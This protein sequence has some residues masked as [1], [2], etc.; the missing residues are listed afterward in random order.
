MIYRSSFRR[1][2]T[3][4]LALGLTVG[5][6][7]AC[8]H[9]AS[10]RGA[11]AESSGSRTVAAEATST[12]PASPASGSPGFVVHEWGL[13]GAMI[14]SAEFSVASGVTPESPS[15]AQPNRAA[16]GKPVIYVH[17]DEG[18]DEARF[19][20]V[21]G[22]RPE[23]ML[24]QWPPSNDTRPLGDATMLSWTGVVAT[25]GACPAPTAPPTADSIAC[26]SVSDQFC[27][28][29][30]IP[31][32]AA[33]HAS[34]LHIGAV[35]TELLFYRSTGLTTT[36][37]PLRII[38]PDGPFEVLLGGGGAGA[39]A[40]GGVEG[41]VLWLE[42]TPDGATRIRPLM[43][44]ERRGPIPPDANGALTPAETRALLRRESVR[45]GLTEAEADAFVDAWA[46]AFFDVCHRSG[47]EAGGLPPYALA[48]AD[49]SLLYF[50]PPETID[51]L[52]PLTT[53]PPAREVRRVF[54][55]RIVGRGGRNGPAR[56]EPTIFGGPRRPPTSPG[57]PIGH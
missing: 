1:S 6:A 37:L 3:V 21:I 9:G 30:E 53:T 38:R 18:I 32:Y 56:T 44:T 25:R 19:D 51:A 31:R 17:L 49:A 36:S 5:T 14:D 45:R 43:P 47:P 39:G 27:E 55:V 52:I 50:A 8:T 23:R 24:E 22:G 40:T 12:A 48:P 26:A 15:V 2:V 13:I 16:P 41:P 34:C 20:L 35:Q 4:T 10:S 54:L 28:A 7:A 11:P 57:D 46:P 33:G 29:A 42:R